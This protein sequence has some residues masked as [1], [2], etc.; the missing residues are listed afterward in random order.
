MRVVVLDYGVGNLYS[1]RHS[2]IRVGANPE[3][4]PEIG[5]PPD[6]LILPGVGNFVAAS[7]LL[8]RLKPVLHDL[9][10]TGLP[11]MGICLGMQLLFESSEEGGGEGLGFL[12][13]K[14]VRLPKSVKVPQI[15]W[16]TVEVKSYHEI[17]NG[18]GEEFWAYFVHSYYPQP[19]STSTI[20]AETE[21]GIRFPSIVAEKNI[22]GTQFHPEKSSSAGFVILKNF[23]RMCR[24]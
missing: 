2:L 21:Y 9:K 6:A 20:V 18:L 5:T 14:V 24:A 23:L 13:G 19:K 10:E 8:K 12:E 16:N 1:I 3:V 4:S 15:G 7:N 17:V 11:I 22:V